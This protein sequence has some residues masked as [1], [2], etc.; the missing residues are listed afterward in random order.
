MKKAL[1]SLIALALM[2]TACA[3]ST[4]SSGTSRDRTET[5]SFD[6]LAREYLVHLPPAYDG[7]RSLP[8]VLAFHGGEGTDEN[9]NKVTHFSDEA[10]SAGFIVVYPNG[11][12]KSWADGRGTTQADK[13]N[14]DDVGFISTLIDTLASAYHIDTTRVYATGISNGGFFSERL[15]C[16]LATKITAI[17]SVAAT[18]SVNLSNRCAPARPMPFMLIQGTDDPLVPFNGGEV[19]GERGAI[20]SAN[21]AVAGWVAIDGCTSTPTQGS[22]PDTANDGMTVQHTFYADCT[23]GSQVR[24]YQVNGGGH[25]WPGGYQYLP[26]VLVGKTSRD[27]DATSLIW[28]FVSQFSLGR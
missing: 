28:N 5:L 4:T 16:D 2:V 6:G 24:F 15:G 13:D 20:I 14:I 11:Y 26:A 21:D 17:V 1:L 18:F 10:D 22:D 27:I 3:R 9:T 25:T 8:L 12:Q 23:S 19:I 7:T